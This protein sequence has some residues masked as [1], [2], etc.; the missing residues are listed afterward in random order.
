MVSLNAVVLDLLKMKDRSKD[1]V[2]SFDSYLLGVY[3]QLEAVQ[4]HPRG[5]SL[6]SE[7]V[8]EQIN[9]GNITSKTLCSCLF[10]F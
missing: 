4:I 5:R 6:N 10:L 1:S 9:D 3:N 7:A 8:N 2:C